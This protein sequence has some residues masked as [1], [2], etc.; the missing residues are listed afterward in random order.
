MPLSVSLGRRTS[1]GF[2]GQF[3][4]RLQLLAPLPACDRREKLNRVGKSRRSKEIIRHLLGDLKRDISPAPRVVARAPDAGVQITLGWPNSTFR[5]GR[6]L[7]EYVERQRPCDMLGIQGSDQRLFRRPGPPRAQLMRRHGPSFIPG[8][9]SGGRRLIVP[10]LLPRS[11]A[12]ARVTKSGALETDRSSARPFSTPDV[13]GA[14]P[15]R[16]ERIRNAINLSWRKPSAARRSGERSS[17]YL[18]Q[19][20]TPSAFFA[21]I[22]DAP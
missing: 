19:P 1:R 5:R 22:L 20:I 13:L 10:G 17:R 2:F 4:E 11:A 18:P 14:F 7:D 6:L 9:R 16:Q 21:V 12:Y 3:D 8:E 15:R